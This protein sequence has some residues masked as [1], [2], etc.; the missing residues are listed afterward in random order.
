MSRYIVTGTPGAGKTVLIEELARRGY[1]SV[2]G[3]ATA[4]IAE[5]SADGTDEHWLADDFVDRIVRRQHADLSRETARVVLHDRSVFCTLALCRHL[6]REV[7]ASLIREIDEVLHG[8]V[9][10]RT[11]F[12]VRPLGFVVPTEARRITYEQSLAFEVWHQRTYAEYGFRLIDVPLG[13]VEQRADLVESV[14][15][16]G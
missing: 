14:L 6:G 12:L 8:N 10:E 1:A 7:P 11:A 2:P 4:V 16:A 9:F 5:M 3:A 13:T 15:M